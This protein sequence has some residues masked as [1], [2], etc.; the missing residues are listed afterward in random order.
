[1]QRP[2]TEQVP[3][4]VL[5]LTDSDLSKPM[6]EVALLLPQCTDEELGAGKG[7]ASHIPCHAGR[8]LW[9]WIQ[10]VIWGLPCGLCVHTGLGVTPMSGPQHSVW[11]L[12]PLAPVPPGQAELSPDSL[13]PV[14][15]LCH[16]LPGS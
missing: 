4:P 8:V 11:R 10:A 7:G 9:N 13:R 16:V 1:M 14:L 15:C 2:T 6:W 5:V 12:P 3:G